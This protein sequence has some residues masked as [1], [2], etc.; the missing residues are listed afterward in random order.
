MNTGIPTTQS[1][2]MIFDSYEMELRVKRIAPESLAAHKDARDRFLRWCSETGVDHEQATRMDMLRY[3]DSLSHLAPSTV[4]QQWIHLH[5]AYRRAASTY[6]MIE[7]DPTAGLPLPAVRRKS[8]VAFS[9][10]TLRAI[11][12]NIT[13]RQDWI[14]FHLLAYTGMRSIEARRL[15]WDDVNLVRNE[16]VLTGKRTARMADDRIVPIH[17]VLR[18]VLL[19]ADYRLGWHVLPG[20]APGS[21]LTRAMIVAYIRRNMPPGMAPGETC[22]PIRRAVASSLRRNGVDPDS[23]D[24]LLGWAPTSMRARRYLAWEA[25]DLSSAINR[26]WADDPL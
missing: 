20:R 6:R 22:H 18:L 8:P 26:L 14:A 21:M 25:T 23:I 13:R 11:K 15:R 4:T 2:G 10:D 3:F 16:L 12:A 17:P 1:V 24:K 19:E 9:A 5:A 7:D